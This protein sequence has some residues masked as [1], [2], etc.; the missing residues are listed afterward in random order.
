MAVEEP[1]AHSLALLGPHPA[2]SRLERE[3][4]GLVEIAGYLVPGG[5]LDQ[6]GLLA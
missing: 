3:H 5:D 6:L 1:Q 2:L 4:K